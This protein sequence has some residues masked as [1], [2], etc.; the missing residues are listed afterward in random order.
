MESAPTEKEKI[1]ENEILKKEIEI[2]KTEVKYLKEN[3]IYKI[4][5]DD[6]KPKDLCFSGP[7][8]ILDEYIRIE[9]GGIQYGPYRHYEQGKYLIIYHGDSLLNAELDVIDNGLNETNIPFTI[10]N[11]SQ[12]K[13]SYEIIVPFEL[14][15]GIEFR[16]FN[17]SSS[18]II[19]V[20]NIEVFKYNI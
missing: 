1:N 18:T 14:K 2:L 5:I 8:K 16:A 13:I 6:L 20:K 10:I 17:K 7:G 12:K 4:K 19:L 15:S 11:K 3:C 9:E